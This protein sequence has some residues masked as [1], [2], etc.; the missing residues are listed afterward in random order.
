M[1]VKLFLAP[2][3]T[4]I[5]DEREHIEFGGLA[6]GALKKPPCAPGGSKIVWRLARPQPRV[7]KSDN[8][9][10][11]RQDRVGGTKRSTQNDVSSLLAAGQIDFETWEWGPSQFE[12]GDAGPDG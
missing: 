11:R 8:S 5:D 4:G 3:Q 12:V 1:D 7:L 10:R 9:T 2:N 6:A